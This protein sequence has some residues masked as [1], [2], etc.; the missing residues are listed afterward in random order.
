ML[1]RPPTPFGL[2]VKT[3]LLEIGQPQEWLIGECRAKTGMYVDS[4][5]MY[6]LLTGQLNSFR[7]KAAIRE[8]LNLPDGT[9]QKGA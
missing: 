6:K 5:T 2:A 8:I 9:G 3:K 7:L 4:S 1:K